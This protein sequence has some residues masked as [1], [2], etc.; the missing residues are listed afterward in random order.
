MQC[1]VCLNAVL[2]GADDYATVVA[3]PSGLDVSDVLAFAMCRT[4]GPDQATVLRKSV[5]VLRSIWP[6]AR[7]V[8][9]HPGAGRA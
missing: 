1:G 6:D 9:V 5:E 2:P 4:G 3:V 8:Q 7:G